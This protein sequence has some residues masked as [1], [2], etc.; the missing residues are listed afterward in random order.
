MLRSVSMDEIS[1]GKLYLA[2]DMVRADTLGCNGCHACCC[3]MGSSILLDPLDIYEL[4]KGLNTTADTL[5]DKQLML[6]FVDG[7]MLPAVAMTKD[8]DQCSFLDASGRCSIHSFRPGFCRLFPL[9]RIYH[10]KS[11]SYFLQTNQCRK[12]H[13]SKIKVRQWINIVQFKR[14]EQYI[15]D[16]HYFL[17]DA[18]SAS[19]G[20]SPELI[21]T[22]QSY[23]L[24]AFYFTPYD[25]TDF[26]DQFYIRLKTATDLLL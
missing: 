2:N 26:Y 13:L 10:D 3:H 1:D 4:S 7:L 19:E 15:S 5:F 18:V 25:T 17:K 23:I 21:K 12:D 16:W 9:G 11:F 14:Y 20:L 6:T 24:K 22:L 8:K